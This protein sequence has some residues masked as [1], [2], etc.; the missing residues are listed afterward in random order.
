M[1]GMRPTD[2]VE[3][4]LGGESELNLEKQRVTNLKNF[5]FLNIFLIFYLFFKK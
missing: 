2:I 4:D 5:I 1:A 3:G